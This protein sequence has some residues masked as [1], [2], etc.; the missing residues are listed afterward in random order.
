MLCHDPGMQSNSRRRRTIKRIVSRIEQMGSKRIKI[1]IPKHAL[2]VCDDF[3]IP[4]TLGN[5]EGIVKSLGFTFASEREQ[6]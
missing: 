3:A 2:V 4:F 5:G 1:E 6:P